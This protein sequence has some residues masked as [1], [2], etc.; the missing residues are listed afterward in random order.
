MNHMVFLVCNDARLE[1]SSERRIFTN[2][3]YSAFPLFIYFQLVHANCS[4]PCFSDGEK[5]F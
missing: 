4:E 5:G 3:T 1:S 2:L